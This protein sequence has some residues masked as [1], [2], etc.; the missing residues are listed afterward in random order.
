METK[1]ITQSVNPVQVLSNVITKAGHITSNLNNHKC[2]QIKPLKE[3]KH[4]K[5]FKR[6][7]PQKVKSKLCSIASIAS[8]KDMTPRSFIEKQRFILLAQQLIN[9]WRLLI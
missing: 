9:I 6:I 3:Q 4:C 1:L 8:N 7:I 5:A 2:Y